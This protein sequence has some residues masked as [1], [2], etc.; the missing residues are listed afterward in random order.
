MLHSSG[1]FSWIHKLPMFGFLGWGEGTVLLAL[2]FLG[3]DMSTGINFVLGGLAGFM[4]TATAAST[5]TSTAAPPPGP[6]RPRDE[7]PLRVVPGL[8]WAAVVCL[9]IV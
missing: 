2:V 4:V 8:S 3:F 6:P 9:N 1:S 7:M 5:T